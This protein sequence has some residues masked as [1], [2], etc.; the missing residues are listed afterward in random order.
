[1]RLTHVLLALAMVTLFL[2]SSV[3]VFAG[4]FFS[5]GSFSAAYEAG[6]LHVQFTLIPGL[7]IYDWLANNWSI[8]P[9]VV[10]LV[11]IKISGPCDAETI[12][13][14]LPWQAESPFV[15][16]DITDASVEA[17]TTYEYFVYGVDGHTGAWS[18][19]AFVGSAS[20]G[21]GFLCRGM[22]AYNPDCG[23]SSV[24]YVITCDNSCADGILIRS[25][26]PQANPYW[27]TPTTLAIYGEVEGLSSAL[28][29]VVSPMY[30]ITSVVEESC[31]SATVP[32]TWGSVKAMY[33]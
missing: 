19:R 33:R 23:V 6:A 9:V 16:S 15:S 14:Y 5:V 26:P 22:L 10:K 24:S 31:V 18:E 21:P 20:T 11:R 8:D 29:N 1:M 30:R 25:S 13:T 2:L 4:T 27:N 12:V 28:C 7:G 32:A 17:G 3:P